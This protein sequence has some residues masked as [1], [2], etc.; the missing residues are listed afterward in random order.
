MKRMLALLTALLLLT[1]L[2]R[3]EAGQPFPVYLNSTA[4]LTDGTGREIVPPGTYD[5]IIPLEGQLSRYAA[6]R[7]ENGVQRFGLM[8]EAGELL[9]AVEYDLLVDAGGEIVCA[10][11]GLYGLLNADG[12]VKVEPAYTSIVPNGEGGALAL[13]TDCWDDQPDGV[14]LIDAQGHETAAGIKTLFLFDSAFSEGRMSLLSAENSRCG[15]VDAQ[16]QWLVRP[17]FAY[18]AEFRDG[19]A[20]ASITSGFGVIDEAGNWVLTPRYSLIWRTDDAF[21]ATEGTSACVAFDA[22]TLE[23]RFRVTGSSLYAYDDGDRVVV[24]DDEATRLYGA[25]GALLFTA[26]PLATLKS[27]ETGLIIAEDGPWGSP[28]ATLHASDGAALSEA[29]QGID[30]LGLVDGAEYFSWFEMDAQPG[31]DPEAEWEYDP[32]SVRFGLMDSTGAALT[33]AV[34]TSLMPGDGTCLVAETEDAV[35]LIDTRGEWIAKWDMEN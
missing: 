6:G 11:D 25:D 12:T 13:K 23:E 15:Y 32:Y 16:G 8:N 7:T 34:F 29:R 28:R 14:Y 35:G 31:E 4:L 21:I 22:A 9:T 2:A 18:A 24:V 17:Q 10:R 5:A 26:S 3:A 33:D 1:P 30:L 19:L 20:I 27:G